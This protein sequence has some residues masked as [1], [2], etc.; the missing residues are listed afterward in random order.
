M[1][2]SLEKDSNNLPQIYLINKPAG[3]SSFD[4]IRDFKR[5]F[6]KKTKHKL[7][8]FGTLDPFAN[9]LLIVGSF[10]AT[11]L[12]NFAHELLPKTYTALGVVGEKRDTGDHTGEILENLSC[13]L[14]LDRFKN[15]FKNGLNHFTGKFEQ[16]P[17]AFS[18][19]KHEGKKLYEYA[20]AGKVIQKDAVERFLYESELINVD[21]PQVEV[22]FKV[23][24][25][26]YIRTL[27]EQVLETFDQVGYLQELERSGIGSL[28]LEQAIDYEVFKESTVEDLKG[29]MPF[30]FIN[31]KRVTL[32]DHRVKWFLNGAS[33]YL[34]S[35]QE[36]PSDESCLTSSEGDYCWVF[37]SSN[38]C[39]GLGELKKNELWPFW[40]WSNI[41]P[42]K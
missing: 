35:V 13:D 20:R 39:L 19:T 4:V 5:K 3:I 6:T 16:V 17:P 23:S 12:M 36:L 11:K 14:D 8:H 10:G 27:F 1:N 33:S 26:T 30:D 41:R 9:G 29:V 24:T 7:G 40:P 25:G 28:S 15:H 21:L 42:S 34:N 31:F 18:A 2:Q 22:R 37:D 38:S 32:A